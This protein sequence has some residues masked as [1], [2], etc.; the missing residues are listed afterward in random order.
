MQ[1]LEHYLKSHPVNNKLTQQ[2]NT[3]PAASQRTSSTVLTIP[4]VVHLVLPASDQALVTEADVIW[5]INKLNEDFSG[6]NADSA[7][8]AAFYATRG[9]SNIRFCLAQRDPAGNPS[10]GINRVYTNI[11]DFGS[12]SA[13]RLK[14]NRTCGADAWNTDQYFNIWVGKS[15]SILGVATFPGTGPNNEQGITIAL[16]GFSN[17]TAY[18]NPAYNQGR[19]VVHETGHYLGLY[20]SWGDEDGCSGSDFRQL[21]GNCLIAGSDIVGGDNDNTIG[22]TPNQGAPTIGCP[23]STQTDNCNS[24]APGVQFQNYM[25]YTDDACYSMFTQLQVKRMEYMLTNCRSS[26]FNSLACT[27]VARFVHDVA[28]TTILN[29]GNGGCAVSGQAEYCAG[30]SFIPTITVKNI[31]TQAITSLKVY[32][33]TDNNPAVVF[34][35][36]GNIPSF[37]TATINLPPVI[38]AGEGSHTIK[39]YTSEPN[40]VAD[41]RPANDTLRATY[42]VARIQA[43]TRVDEEFNNPA[44]PPADWKVV[45]P[46]NDFTWQWHATAGRKAPGSVW[47]NDWNN[48]MLDRFDDLVTPNFSISDIDSVFLH[49]QVANAMYSNPNSTTVPLDTLTIL[50][51][52]DCGHTYTQVYKKWGKDLQTVSNTWPRD[53]EF[54]PRTGADWRRD[55]VY[56][57]LVLSTTEKQFQV[58]FRLSANYENNIFIDD[59]TLYT[60]VLPQALKEKGLLVLPTVNKGQFSVWHYHQPTDLQ[61]VSVFNAKG[62]LVWRKQYRSNAEKLIAVNLQGKAAGIYFVRLTYQDAG[63]NLTQRIIKQ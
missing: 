58:A 12:L 53:Q 11:T 10:N 55:S 35:W 60:K 59:I 21:P 45:N 1:A 40:G 25:D 24:S 38:A 43:L 17:N 15:T 62:Q 56:L 13:N 27:P 6:D 2:G 22:D 8:G 44:F 48:E 16:D 33:Q 14:S 32:F 29:P 52:K 7:S 34:N 57:G 51:S 39:I 23:G 26:L 3:D 9:R 19:T 36:T 5:Q 63:R 4:V 20:H 54:F 28:L 47:F 41:Q 42:S 31:G 50:V 49:F 61:D 46:D 30:S 18:V 37:A